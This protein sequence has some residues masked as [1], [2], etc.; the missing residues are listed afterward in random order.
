[1]EIESTRLAPV[2]PISDPRFTKTGLVQ[3]FEQS[4]NSP[5]GRIRTNIKKIEFAPDT[6]FKKANVDTGLLHTTPLRNGQVVKI[7]EFYSG[8]DRIF[9]DFLGETRGNK[10]I[11]D[12]IVSLMKKVR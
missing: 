7:L 5:W 8:K 10:A 6:F 2:V 9:M 3:Y 11:R 12:Y 1:M 4:Q